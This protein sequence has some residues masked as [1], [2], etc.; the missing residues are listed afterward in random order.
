MSQDQH[1]D[2]LAPYKTTFCRE[3]LAKG[4]CPRGPNC[5]FAHS[6]E[7]RREDPNAP[8]CIFFPSGKCTNV[9]CNFKHN[10]F[11]R[12]AP[13]SKPSRPA[14]ASSPGPAPAATALKTLGVQP[15]R[16]V[17]AASIE[18]LGF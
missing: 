17:T 12:Q 18:A 14:Q 15:R 16:G 3:Y 2:Y 11:L 1:R 5:R 8:D 9:Y 7:E 4:H 6:L 13:G 10:P